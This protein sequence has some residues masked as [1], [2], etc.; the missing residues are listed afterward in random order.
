M[1][2]GN[3][4]RIV[5]INPNSTEAVTAG[6]DTSVDALRFADGPVIHCLTL[7]EGPPGIETQQHID[8]VIDPLCDLI[9]HEDAAADAFV[10]A[11]F[12]D[13]GLDAARQRTAKPVIGC[14]ESA[15]LTALMLGRR[16]GVIAI[17]PESVSRQQRYVRRLGLESHYAASLPV[18]LGVTALEGDGVAARLA[19]VGRRL[20]ADHGAEV[21]ILGCAGMARHRETLA[22]ALG[23]PVVDP[24]QAGVAHALAAVR[25]GYPTAPRDG[26]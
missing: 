20:V 24:A 4:Q 10:I 23:V 3:G 1:T 19:D 11:C 13:P 16:F 5:V 18:G 14:S 26:T 12:S 9:A 25:L 15:F 8:G 22:A 2:G 21:L 17:L 7:A 6:I